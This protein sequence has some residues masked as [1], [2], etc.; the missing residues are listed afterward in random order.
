MRWE[1]DRRWEAH[2]F[3]GDNV[4]AVARTPGSA[5]YRLCMEQNAVTILK[6]SPCEMIQANTDDGYRHGTVGKQWDADP[7]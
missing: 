7:G 4:L 2:L 1:G 5:N 3:A 6:S